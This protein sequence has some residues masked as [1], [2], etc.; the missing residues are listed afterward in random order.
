MSSFF[1]VLFI[2]V[3]QFISRYKDVLFG[4]GFEMFEIL[5]VF[6]FASAKLVVL[7]LPLSTLLS[8]LITMGNM[9]ENYEIAA[10]KASGIST[11]RIMRPMFGLTLGVTLFSL[12]FSFYVVPRANLKL[13]SLLYDM[14]VAKPAF[15]LKPGHF[16]NGIEGYTLRVAEKNDKTEMLK[17]IMIYD[18]TRQQGNNKVVM[19]D[20]GW[21]YLDEERFL[22]QM[23]LFGGVSH[24]SYVNREREEETYR[25]GRFYFDTLVFRFD[26]SD[27]GIQRT[28]EARFSSHQ[29]MQDIFE[30]QKSIDSVEM[31]TKAKTESFRLGL[32]PFLPG[33]SILLT[34][35]ET[36][37]PG[38]PSS[39]LITYFDD[40]KAAPIL[41]Q[42]LQDA[43]MIRQFAQSAET[44]LWEEGKSK[45]NYQIELQEKFSLP[46]SCLIF[47]LIGAPLGAIIRKGGLGM[48]TLISISLF[49]LFYVLLIQGKKLAQ[50][51]VLPVFVGSWL[52]CL[53]LTPMA[54]FFTYESTTDSQLLSSAFW[55]NLMSP[56]RWLRNRIFRIFRRI[57]PGVDGP[58]PPGHYDYAKLRDMFRE[59]LESETGYL[60]PAESRIV[61]LSE[62]GENDP[63]PLTTPQNVTSPAFEW[64][65]DFLQ[66]KYHFSG[67][68][69]GFSSGEMTLNFISPDTEITANDDVPE[70]VV[71]EEDPPFTPI[72][73]GLDFLPLEREDLADAESKFGVDLPPSESESWSLSAALNFDFGAEN[74]SLVE[75]GL[76]ETEEDSPESKPEIEAESPVLEFIPEEVPEPLVESHLSEIEEDS[77]ESK[78]EIEAESPVLEFIPEEVPEPLVESHLSEIEEDS[79]ESEAEIEAEL[80]VFEFIPEEVPEPLVESHLPEFEE[81]SPEPEPEIEAESPV[82]E[83][84]PE[85][86]PEPLVES[87]LPELEEDS[88]EPEPEIETE[89]PVLEFIPE[90]INMEEDLEEDDLE[91]DLEE[92]EEEEDELEEEEPEEIEEKP[93]P[94]PPTWGYRRLENPAPEKPRG[95]I[96]PVQL[97]DDEEVWW[98][99][100]MEE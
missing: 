14:Q 35:E 6:W 61:P 40:R 71:E 94:P 85:E 78:P 52:P 25:Y 86:I 63:P 41:R 59:E 76:P 97:D 36:T 82:L 91:D 49:I 15:N 11:A 96:K 20:S 46:I 2:L 81:D 5:K 9:G 1:V 72:S 19:A 93:A 16:Y 73:L 62:L 29:Y 92:E 37:L 83:F 31:V 8:S 42:S 34:A 28:D 7:A 13:F 87:H 77:P 43:D 55:Y 48:P 90:P 50:D 51:D 30:L 65:T 53:V 95:Y 100:S 66:G 23:T 10:L 60:E 68:N 57:R 21:M 27:F 88:P 69:E 56:F 45:R 98:D 24:E 54:L 47:L 79:P 80:P 58:P 64:Q 18:H 67:E 33:D 99:G 3:L 39:G 4:K 44:Q 26:L 89:S 22:L 75:K 38:I 70:P 12:L 74:V 17:K 32:V 84:N